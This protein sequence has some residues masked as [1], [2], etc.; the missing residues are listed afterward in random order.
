MTT[1]V[2]D[3]NAPNK[4]GIATLPPDPFV[5]LSA[6]GAGVGDDASQLPT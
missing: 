6:C 4:M 1:V 5:P 3:N 2:I